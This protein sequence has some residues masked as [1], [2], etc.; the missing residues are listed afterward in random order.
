MALPSDDDSIGDFDDESGDVD[1]GSNVA[2]LRSLLPSFGHG[3][4]FAERA[5]VLE[6]LEIRAGELSCLAGVCVRA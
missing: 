2:V 4:G 5:P 1:D 6:A 3:G